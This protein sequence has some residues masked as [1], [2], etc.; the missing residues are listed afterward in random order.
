MK[1]RGHERVK[2]TTLVAISWL[3]KSSSYRRLCAKITA[4]IILQASNSADAQ[5]KFSC[6]IA[7]L[8]LRVALLSRL[9]MTLMNLE[10]PASSNY[11]TKEGAVLDL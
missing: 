6:V 7:M 5:R 10:G 11:K 3:T 9:M 1:M 4:N 8:S 2:S